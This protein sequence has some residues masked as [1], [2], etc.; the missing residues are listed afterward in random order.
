MTQYTGPET[1]NERDSRVAAHNGNALDK[2]ALSLERTNQILQNLATP[3]E[4]LLR[5]AIATLAN[6]PLPSDADRKDL[7]QFTA[8]DIA[9]ALNTL[10]SY[11]CTALQ[12]WAPTAD[13][14]RARATAAQQSRETLG[15]APQDSTTPQ[16]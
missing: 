16:P 10:V 1:R 15:D 9:H 14:L 5:L 13:I 7:L 2:I 3:L 8:Y 12:A 11:A 6:P 4:T